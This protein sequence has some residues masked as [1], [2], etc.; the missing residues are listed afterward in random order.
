MA[1]PIPAYALE[2]H[3]PQHPLR[4]WLGRS[5]SVRLVQIHTM[6]EHE[7]TQE[8]RRSQ[9]AAA[10]GGDKV[11]DTPRTLPDALTRERCPPLPTPMTT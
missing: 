2:A 4:S 6:L 5:R 11:D 3:L 1:L 9:Q 10:G 8:L 7:P